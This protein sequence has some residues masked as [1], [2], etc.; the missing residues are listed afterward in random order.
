MI[1]FLFNSIG[2][3]VHSGILAPWCQDKALSYYSTILRV[4][5]SSVLSRLA[6]GWEERMEKRRKEGMTLPYKGIITHISSSGIPLARTL[7]CDH[8]E[9][10]RRLGNVVYIFTLPTSVQIKPVL[11]EDRENGF[12]SLHRKHDHNGKIAQ[13]KIGYFIFF[14]IRRSSFI[15]PISI[16]C[17]P[18]AKYKF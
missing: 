8:T 15:P 3:K 11:M 13:K 10:Q 18:S 9:L 17:I 4:V 2:I 12:G 14:N 1:Y 5:P 6:P 16:Q 7:S